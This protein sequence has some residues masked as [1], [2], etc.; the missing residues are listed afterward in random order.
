MTLYGKEERWKK[1]GKEAGQ[2]T[3]SES[4]PAQSE[5]D[6]HVQTDIQG[7]EA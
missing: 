4:L 5:R 1:T 7:A 3:A 2:R 6:I